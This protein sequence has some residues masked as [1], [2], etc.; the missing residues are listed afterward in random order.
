[1]V[2]KD[3]PFYFKLFQIPMLAGGTNGFTKPAHRYTSAGCRSM[4]GVLKKF[5]E[6][7]SGT[8]ALVTIAF[9]AVRIKS[10]YSYKMH[11]RE[12]ERV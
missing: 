5:R 6:A 8:D 4:H 10:S 11:R 12:D 2:R 9:T 3:H 1:M 7:G